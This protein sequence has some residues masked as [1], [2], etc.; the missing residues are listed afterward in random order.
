[1]KIASVFNKIW[2]AT[3]EHSPEILIV[4]SAVG[5]VTGTVLACKATLKVNNVLEEAKDAV[6]KIHEVQNNPEVPEEKYSDKDA[7]K[8]LAIV[9]TQTAWKLT[10]LYAP[11]V[12][13]MGLSL[14][15]MF[16]S[17]NILRKRNVALAAAY[18]TVDKAFTEYRKRVIDKY[19]EEIDKELKYG[20]TSKKIE[21]EVTD[22]ETGKT[23]KV[24]KTIELASIE[25]CSPYA[26][27]FD[28][29]T[30]SC[31]EKNDD[32]TEMFLRSQ[33][34]YMNDTLRVKGV[35]TLREV[36]E[37]LG[38][39]WGCEEWNRLE[40]ASLVVGWKTEKDQVADELKVDNKFEYTKIIKTHRELED[41]SI[42]PTRIIDF[43]VDG[44]IYNR[45]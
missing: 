2:T 38:I 16:T 18:T 42:I 4:A 7:K 41:G 3:K 44:N 5:V 19:G 9:Y 31:Y 33:E 10:K 29:F 40:K 45:L 12:V 43:N 23:K 15:A 17:N 32:Y 22:E 34:R 11:A 8:D 14:T 30:S 39:M 25:G 24:K 28:K 20:I 37:S 1:M 6:D 36:L 35:L 21:E 27:Y 13:L 26:I